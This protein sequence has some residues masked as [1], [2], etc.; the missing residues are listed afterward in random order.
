MARS[1]NKSILGDLSGQVGPVVVTE[2]RGVAVVRSM[3]NK[4]RRKK[5][6]KGK[7][8]THTTS[9]GKVVSLLR[10][11]LHV[12]NLGY[13]Q[14]RSS[15]MSAINAAV[16]W[17]FNNALT[18]DPDNPLLNMA[19]VK[20]SFPIKITQKAWEAELSVDAEYKVT[21]AWKLNPAPKKCT[22]L[23]DRAVIVM[24]HDNGKRS[25]FL[26]WEN[27]ALRSDLNFTFNLDYWKKGREVHFYM[28]MISADNKLV[29][30]TQY[31]GRIE[32]TQ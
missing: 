5:P 16:S 7:K 1:K 12:I 24:Y 30:D 17:N 31:L 25:R 20:L 2:S 10:S 29:S 23:D 18:N 19:K 27:A 13:P 11:A 3:P 21:I 32:L 9:F 8:K 22:Q 14:S 26:S 6:L 15:H 28:F 4:P